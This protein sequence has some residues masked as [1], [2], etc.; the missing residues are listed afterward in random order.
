M[1]EALPLRYK[2]RLCVKHDQKIKE[3]TSG[4]TQVT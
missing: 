2:F 4:T 3:M 1:L